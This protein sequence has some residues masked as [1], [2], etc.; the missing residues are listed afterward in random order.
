MKDNIVKVC[1]KHGELREAQ[2]K[3][4][5]NKSGNQVYRCHLCKIEKDRKWK[6]NNKDKHIAASM[7]WKKNNKDRYKAWCK[8]DRENN[9]EK[10]L[11]WQR[12]GR[13]KEGIFRS[14]KEVTRLRGITVDQYYSMVGEQD[15]K[16]AICFC[17]ETRMSRTK[18]K[19][20]RLSIDHHHASGMVRGLLCH[21]CNQVVGHSK[22][23][24]EVLKNAIL[25]L[26][27][28]NCK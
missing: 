27:K 9:P 14:I 11:E 4:E 25:Y 7:R 20:S 21:G 5:I 22:E 10:Y 18:G 3:K 24:I 17:K 19:I 28:H 26:E 8:K 16:C 12:I 2:T 23:S 1:K 6:S 15:N 13:E